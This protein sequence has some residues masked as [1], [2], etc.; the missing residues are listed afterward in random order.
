MT[1][2]TTSNNSSNKSETDNDNNRS[3]LADDY[4]EDTNPKIPSTMAQA[5]EWEDP[6]AALRMY[7]A[8]ARQEAA[9]KAT[10]LEQSILD[11]TTSETV[12]PTLLLQTTTTTDSPTLETALACADSIQQSLSKIASGGSAASCEIRELESSKH[13]LETHAQA[14]E[15][16]L[17][18]RNNDDAALQALQSQDWQTAAHAVRPWLEWSDAGKPKSTPQEDDRCRQYS[19]CWRVLFA[20]AGYCLQSFERTVTTSL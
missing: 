6:V 17:Q 18:L 13:D 3:L 7:A 2:T 14:V 9:Q 20:A 19:V 5:L 8:H 16:A 15:M 11:P 10:V 12:V 4:G 1:S